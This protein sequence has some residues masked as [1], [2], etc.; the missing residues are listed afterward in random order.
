VRAARPVRRAAWG[1]GSGAIPAPRPRPTQL[2]AVGGE[3]LALMVGVHVLDPA[4]D[5]P[6][7]HVLGL[8]LGRERGVGDLGDLGIADPA[9]LVLVEDRIDV[10]DRRPGIRLDAGDRGADGPVLPGGDREACLLPQGGGDHLGAVERRV[11]PQHQQPA[12]ARL[13]RRDQGVG[14]EAAGASG[15]I[16][17]SLA[18]PGSG[19]HRR[20]GRR[21]DDRQQRVQALDPGV[22]AAGALLGVAVGLAQRVI[23]ID[24]GQ[25][26]GA[27][28]QR[29][30]TGQVDQQPRRHGVE[31][32]D[33]TEGERAQERPQRRRRPDPG[34]QPLH[35]TVPQ[36]AHVL[37]RVRAGDHPRNQSRD[38]QMGIDTARPTQV[39]MLADQALQLGPLRQAQDR[40]QASAR[41]Q[42]RVIEQGRNLMADS[43]PADA[44]LC[45]VNRSL[46]KIDSPAAGGHSVVATRTSTKVR[47]WI[48]A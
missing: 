40:R 19:D 41:H 17:R 9:L 14:D 34:E 22:A 45:V 15:A 21:G 31:L 28:Q 20:R 44:L 26:V 37:D 2:V 12:R 25:L 4:H 23:H 43:H 47:R 8:G 29:R 3:Q 18:Q 27:G 30:L 48:R 6:G 16:G 5:Q 7:G 42:V 33:M 11:R 32:T 38:L 10:L 24:V 46:D 39:H 35:R 13:V 1:N 36:Q